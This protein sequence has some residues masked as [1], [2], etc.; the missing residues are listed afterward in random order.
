MTPAARASSVTAHNANATSTSAEDRGAAI[1]PRSFLT[2][3]LNCQCQKGEWT[4]TERDQEICDQQKLSSVLNSAAGTIAVAR[5]V[6]FLQEVSQLFARKGDAV[7][8]FENMQGRGTLSFPLKIKEGTTCPE[9]LPPAP[10][11]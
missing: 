6:H 8:S 9:I 2:M 4:S 1:I 5:K 7:V 10:K 11:N 3:S